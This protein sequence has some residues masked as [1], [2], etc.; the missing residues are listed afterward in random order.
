MKG[1]IGSKFIQEIQR[2]SAPLE[3]VAMRTVPVLL[4]NGKRKVNAL[5]DDCSTKT[6][7]NADVV[8]ELGLEDV[9]YMSLF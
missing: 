5:L 6:Y 1:L 2:K 3:C 8:S 7:L 9:Q 4:G